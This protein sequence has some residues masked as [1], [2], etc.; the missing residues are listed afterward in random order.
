MFGVGGGR[1][2]S[3]VAHGPNSDAGELLPYWILFVDDCD[4][5]MMHY[6]FWDLFDPFPALPLSQL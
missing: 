5:F 4:C 1:I 6:F 2:F 3:L